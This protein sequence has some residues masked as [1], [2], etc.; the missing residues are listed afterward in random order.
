LKLNGLTGQVLWGKGVTSNSN[1]GSQPN[2]PSSI[3]ADSAGAVHVAGAFEAITLQL[4]S[5]TVVNADSAGGTQDVFIWR[6]AASDGAHLGAYRGGG[7]G[8]DEANSLHTDHKRHQMVIGGYS[9]GSSPL[10]SLDGTAVTLSGGA[11]YA[12]FSPISLCAAGFVP[13]STTAHTVL[14][15]TTSG[16]CTA[17][18]TG[19]HSSIHGNTG[20][21]PGA[22]STKCMDC[23]NDGCSSSDPTEYCPIVNSTYSLAAA[24]ACT[25][26]EAGHSCPSATTSIVC[27]S[28]SYSGSGYQSCRHCDPGKYSDGVGRKAQCN[29][30]SQVCTCAECDKGKVSNTSGASA[31]QTCTTGQYNVDRGAVRCVACEAGRYC[32]DPSNDGTECDAGSFSGA[33]ASE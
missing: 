8:N 2:A 25:M 3:V 5:D 30:V 10:E 21:L 15:G 14:A 18:S 23:F 9:E 27:P 28:G 20:E 11:E 7:L 16:G 13:D 17:C 12:W 22:F 26:C 4:G 29:L 32:I 6:L 31:C 33:G 24:A 19:T 1:S